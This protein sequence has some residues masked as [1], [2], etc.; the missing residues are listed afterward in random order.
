[1]KLAAALVLAIALGCASPDAHLW[2]AVTTALPSIMV[3]AGAVAEPLAKAIAARDEK[4]MLTAWIRVL[5]EASA[6]IDLRVAR[7]EISPEVAESLRE[8]LRLFGEALSELQ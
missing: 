4:A 2:A 7:G 6:A 8:R 3:E 1:M 5:P